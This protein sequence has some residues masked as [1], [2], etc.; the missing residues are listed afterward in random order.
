ML[1]LFAKLVDLNL[2]YSDDQFQRFN[3]YITKNWY[4]GRVRLNNLGLGLESARTLYS[5][6]CKNSKIK[7]LNVNS[8]KFGDK[9]AKILAK[10]LSV[11]TNLISFSIASNGL[12]NEGCEAIITPIFKNNTLVSLKIFNKERVNRNRISY[13]GVEKLSQ[14]LKVSKI[15]TFID[16]SLLSLGDTGVNQIWKGVTGIENGVINEDLDQDSVKYSQKCEVSTPSEVIKVPNRHLSSLVLANNELTFGC[17]NSIT[18]IVLQTNLEHLNLSDNS[19]GDKSIAKFSSCLLSGRWNLKILELENWDLTGPG[20]NSF[21]TALKQNG[22]I[23]SINMNKNDLSGHSIIKWKEILHTNHTITKI[24]LAKWKLGDIGAKA[25]AQGLFR[26]KNITHLNLCE[27]D[28]GDKGAESFIL[29]IQGTNPTQISLWM[30]NLS[31]N[32]INDIAAMQLSKI[33]HDVD[34]PVCQLCKRLRL[35]LYSPA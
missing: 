27:N 28:I 12:T 4:N 22:S 32:M 23:K 9:G 29:H 20:C 15:L 8:N 16:L 35:I 6:I 10:I 24:S 33:L 3:R 14:L 17:I 31:N 30:L 34:R 5:I 25:I 26:N 18:D 11:S 1:L 21:L 19:L 7:R 13:T 2:R